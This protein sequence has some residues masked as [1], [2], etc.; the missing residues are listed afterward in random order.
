MTTLRKWRKLSEQCRRCKLLKKKD[1]ELLF[2]CEVRKGWARAV[3]DVR[4]SMT[5]T[6][7]INNR[8][9]LRK[10]LLEEIEAIKLEK[11]TTRKDPFANARTSTPEPRY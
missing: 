10:I 1:N 6:E 8:I 9:A 4:F 7:R 11:P 2:F 3:C 5:K